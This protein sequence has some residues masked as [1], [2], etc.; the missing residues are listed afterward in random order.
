MSK[1]EKSTSSLRGPLPK[2]HHF[3][4]GKFTFL[5][6]TT[7]GHGRSIGNTLQKM[8]KDSAVAIL[9]VRVL[10]VDV[11]VCSKQFSSDF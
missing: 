3:T 2:N 10:W 8:K 7:V 6:S 4:K 11:D 5:I 9:L 1:L